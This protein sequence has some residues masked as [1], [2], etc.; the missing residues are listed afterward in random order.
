MS[1]TNRGYDRHKS[2]YYAT[3]IED[4]KLFLKE[5]CRVYDQI[6]DL[7]KFTFTKPL[8]IL[9]PCA[10]NLAYSDAIKNYDF[11]DYKE[12]NTIDIRDDSAAL[13]QAN[14]LTWVP[15]KK[16]DL[17]ISNPPFYLALDFIKK[18]LQD[19][20]DGGL[21]IMLLRL[22]FLGSQER[23]PFW[24]EN[25]ANAA[26]IHSKRMKFIKGKSGD[27]CEYAHFVWQKGNPVG[28]CKLKVI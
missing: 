22:N 1:S 4:I 5:F 27:S 7:D 18:A 13:I 28:F 24:K 19:V 11:P 15:D 12:I 23:L 14:Y 20:Q 10:G 6:I 16:Y 2:D 3:P 26:F 21:V 8:N 9:D 25:M 17:I